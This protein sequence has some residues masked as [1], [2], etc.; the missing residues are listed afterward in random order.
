[1]N[2]NSLLINLLSEVLGPHNQHYENKGQISF[3]CPVCSYDIKGLNKGDGKG[4]FEIN[5]FKGVYKCWAC[6]E[7]HETHG[8]INKLFWK[9][10]NKKHR[11]NWKLIAPEKFIPENKV[12]KRIE[13]P[14]D[15]I[16]FEK[17]NKL[18]IS[19]KEARNYLLN[20]NISE[21]KMIKYSMGYT[22]HGPYR[23]RIIIPSF[24]EDGEINYFVARSYTNHRMKYKN[25]EFP[26]EEIIF[27]ESRIKW[28]ED[29]YLVE[30][31][32]DMLF[33]D[34]AIPILGKTVSDNLWGKLYEKSEKNIIVCLDGDAWEDAEQL[35]RKLDGGR[36]NNRIRVIK[37]PKDK[38]VAE[39]GGVKNLKM[40]TLL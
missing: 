9:W 39:L 21:D 8:S 35:Y 14:D 6:S 40:L 5:Y 29:I 26:K 20:R 16:S 27:N 24:D 11:Q 37:M 7:T 4:N 12:Y 31:V 32:F 10:G 36:L 34:N 17:G 25:P 33:L 3:D 1:M 38:D 23:G 30:G 19:Y 15:F 28:D 13:L 22:T 2:D 18:T